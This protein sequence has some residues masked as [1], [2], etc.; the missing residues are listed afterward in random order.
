MKKYDFISILISAIIFLFICNSA[1]AKQGATNG[2]K[3]CENIIIPALLPILILT[4]II[5]KSKCSKLFEK[6][7]G[8]FAYYLFRL[9][10]C[11][12]PAII[13]GLIGGYPAGA[14]L[15]SSLLEQGMI[16]ENEAKRIMRINFSGGLAFVISAVGGI[17]LENTELGIALYFSSII[18]SIIIGIINGVFSKSQISTSKA[19]YNPL[20]LNDALI[21]AVENATK[22]I[23]IMSSY[24]IL[25]SS[26]CAIFPI[27]SVIM[28]S[29]EITNGI[30]STSSLTIEQIAF[31]L[32]FGG[33]CIHFQI[34]SYLPSYIDFL[35]FRIISSISSYGLM[36]LY[37][38]FNPIGESVF[39]N[40]ASIT[41]KLTEVNAGFGIIMI[42]G[43]AVIV[44]DIENRR[45]KLR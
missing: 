38:L 25:F 12:A 36:K 4:N 14:I 22:S 33:I 8:W 24:I 23:L 10:K 15:T 1:S 19:F 37:L 41:P 17:K 5:I 27:S 3:L 35:I 30:Y 32:A 28:P 7:F 21:N 26:I 42:I 44:F 11:T 43:C 18:P 39:S 31:F 45:L 2:I 20:S 13:L 16:S 40:Q 34:M 6:L 29:I 9:P